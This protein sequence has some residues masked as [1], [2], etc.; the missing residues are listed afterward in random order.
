MSKYFQG[1][2]FPELIKEKVPEQKVP[3]DFPDDFQKYL[4]DFRRLLEA[5]EGGQSTISKMPIDLSRS[6]VRPAL[7]RLA[8][9]PSPV[10]LRIFLDIVEQEINLRA[11]RE[12]LSILNQNKKIKEWIDLKLPGVN[13]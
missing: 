8:Y 6:P 12:L 11:R 1:V 13:K 7:G 3:D 2:E 9:A 5:V 10:T 4:P